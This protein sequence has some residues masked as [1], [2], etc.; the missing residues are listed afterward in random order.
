MYRKRQR[1][2]RLLLSLTLASTM[3]LTAMPAGADPGDLVTTLEVPPELPVE[4][5]TE[6]APAGSLKQAPLWKEI[7]QLLDDPYTTVER[8]PGFGVTMP[9][10]NV[11]E[12]ERNV[13]TDEP[14]RL[15]TS[16]GE[17]SWDKPGFLFDPDQQ[18]ADFGPSADIDTNDDN[19][20]DLFR[21]VIGS[22][23]AEDAVVDIDGEE[24]TVPNGNL[25]VDNPDSDVRIPPDGTVVAVPAFI[26]GGLY[27]YDPADGARTL[28]TEFEKPLTEIDFLRETTDTAGVSVPLRPYIGRPAAELL[29]KAL[30]WD[31][32][33]GSDGVQACGTCHFAAG[34]DPRTKNQLN[35]NHLG[36]DSTLQVAGTNED[37]TLSDFPFRKLANPQL[38]SEGDPNQVVISDANDVMSSM[39]V[40]YRDFVDIPVPGAAAFG[41]AVS[42]VRPLLPDVGTVEAD[43]IGAFIDPNTGEN[44]RRVEPRNTP[45]MHSAAFNFDNFWDGR[46]RHDFNGG[47]VQGASDPAFHIFQDLGA[48]LEG[49]ADAEDPTVPARI[50]FSSLGSQAVGPPLS[51]FEMS[52][53][54]RN[55][56]KIGKKLLQNVST[57]VTPLA[58]QLVDVDDSV[59]GPFSNQGGSIAVAMGR[60]TAV[61][62]PGLAFTYDEIIEIAFKPE[63]WE[64]TDEHLEG[65]PSADP[66]DGYELTLANGAAT[67]ID[68]NEFTQMEANFSLFFALGVQMYEELLI[69]DDSA[70]DK[71]MDANPNAANGV[72]QPG[73]R[74]TLEPWRV[75]EL[76]GPLTLIPDNPNTPFYDGFGEDELYGFDIFAGANLTAA[77]PEGSDRNPIQVNGSNETTAVG[78]NPFLRT[79]RC[80]QC[81]LGPEQTDSSL[82]VS[83]GVLSSDSEYEFPTPP[84]SPEATG[85]FRLL[86][87]LMLADEYEGNAPDGIEVEPRDMQ[88]IDDPNTPF[89]DRTVSVPSAFAIG[90]QGIYNIGLRPASEDNGRGEND[91][92][93][94]PLSNTAMA[95]KNLGGA[96][97]EPQDTPADPTPGAGDPMTTFDPDIDTGGGLFE[98]TGGGLDYPGAPGY[99]LQSINPGFETEAANPLLPAYLAPWILPMGGGELHPELDELLAAP[100]TISEANSG[101]AVEFGEILFGADLHSGVYDPA[102]FGAGAPNFGW[103][104]MAPNSQS[105]VPN[106][107]NGPNQG[108]WPFANRVGRNGAFKAPQLRNIELTGPYFHTGSYLTL[109]QV[110]DFYVRG[111]DFPVTNAEVRDQ[112]VVNI[113][114][115]AFGFGSSRTVSNGGEI[116]DVPFGDGLPDSLTQYDA[117]PDQDHDQTP[118]PATSNPEE[119]KESMVKFLISL[120]DP[121]VKCEQAPFDRPELFV[122]VDGTAADNTGGRAQLLADPDFLHIEA[123]GADGRAENDCLPNF[124]GVS[125]TPI[126]GAGNDHFD[127]TIAPVVTTLSLRSST[128]ITVNYGVL[129]GMSALLADDDGN[130]ISGQPVEL[131]RSFNNTTWSRVTTVTTDAQG[132][133]TSMNYPMERNTYFKMVFPGSEPDLL[134]GSE[135]GVRT[136]MCRAY[137]STPS[138]TRRSG[139]TYRFSGYLKPRHTAGSYAV[140]TYVDRYQGGRWVTR[141]IR[142]TQVSN[143]STYSRYSIDLL[144]PQNGRWR[145]RE[146]HADSSH[147]PTWSS[148][149]YFTVN[150]P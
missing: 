77:L 14:L 93:G 131:W 29:G 118:E 139:R 69:P 37:V 24:F 114:K 21:T 112:H 1:L 49:M 123:L 6:L 150:V 84:D 68:T 32:Q 100:N 113:E 13:F 82:N 58:N 98:E 30:F 94:W 59:L 148:Y 125:S 134:A 124:L 143:Y 8:R 116:P 33:V 99:D 70:F 28:I 64:N 3:M 11:W 111:G 133:A 81:H 79:A 119:A 40:K 72:G 61:G 50:R 16:D 73:E 15:R 145:V 66:F 60:P 63:L 109:R 141:R 55:W 7:V 51:D 62:K 25:V 47:S 101:P 57:P 54:G 96:D 86:N 74:G 142:Y 104:P 90:D 4:L 91:A 138:A 87:P 88:A 56:A 36:G 147:A 19:T 27:E 130:P 41:P 103:G 129:S 127:A 136:V 43:P 34:A 67:A 12:S 42:G 78:S 140:R 31:M 89:D 10:L 107:F 117:M 105:G 92:F 23:V 44:V 121:R 45:T 17:I 38:A 146:Y 115:Q 120:T 65:A 20:P 35:P 71:F 83:T 5:E 46:A 9:A 76:V 85:E 128:P 144:L 2:L 106:N 18:D 80:A 110:V 108:T 26:N 97:F 135:S 53:A 52:F 75:V 137:L 126:D 102:N 22:L 149:R 122:P 39:G 95:L 48:G 132:V